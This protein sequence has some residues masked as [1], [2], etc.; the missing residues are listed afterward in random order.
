[1]SS[2]TITHIT[3]ASGTEVDIHTDVL[4]SA[5]DVV[6]IANTGTAY[7][8]H[9]YV[10]V[11]VGATSF[12][13]DVAPACALHATALSGDWQ[14]STG[15]YG[16]LCEPVDC[17]C[18]CESSDCACLCEP[19]DCACLCSG[20]DTSAG[21]IATLCAQLQ[22]LS[23]GE[24]GC[25]T[26]TQVASTLDAIRAVC[27]DMSTGNCYRGVFSKV[28]NYQVNNI[29]LHIEDLLAAL[30][31]CGRQAFIPY[32]GGTMDDVDTERELHDVH[33][34]F[35]FMR[36]Y[37]RIIKD[38]NALD[39]KAIVYAQERHS[40]EQADVAYRI[41][42][43]D[44]ACA[45]GCGAARCEDA[46]CQREV[47]ACHLSWQDQRELR[48]KRGVLCKRQER[49][50]EHDARLTQVTSI[51]D[52]IHDLLEHVDEV[53]GAI[54]ALFCTALLC[55]QYDACGHIVVNATFMSFRNDVKQHLLDLYNFICLQAHAGIPL[56]QGPCPKQFRYQSSR[57]CSC[58]TDGDIA[59]LA[60]AQSKADAV[61]TLLSSDAS[62]LHRNMLSAL[63]ALDMVL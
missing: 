48:R 35:R 22:A 33:N 32:C 6:A 34:V 1:M 56:G 62:S 47:A 50:Q 53:Y 61:R 59:G 54:H 9:D 45:S 12:R 46:S 52:T 2:G 49:L 27:G 17:A 39:Q 51:A 60:L 30:I 23:G 11:L 43:I 40:N 3:I 21:L 36:K 20:V 26:A 15:L 29:D 10:V 25:L 24:C 7:D 14:I 5:D 42:E 58:V 44:R 38:I 19:A 16:C 57:R 55:T 4:P 28:S 37:V 41:S 8:G 13:V 18:L 63:S 31:S